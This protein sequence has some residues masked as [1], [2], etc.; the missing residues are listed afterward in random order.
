MAAELLL[1]LFLTF[2][3]LLTSFIFLHPSSVLLPEDDKCK[4]EQRA[5]P[6]ESEVGIMNDGNRVR[7]AGSRILTFTNTEDT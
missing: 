4:G 7:N 3:E 1:S 6:P 5:L 2:C